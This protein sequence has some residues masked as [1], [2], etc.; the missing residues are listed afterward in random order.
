MTQWLALAGIATLCLGVGN[1]MAQDQGGPGGPG[2]GRQRGNFDPAQFQQRMMEG[3]RDRLAITDETEWN[4]I[5]P[6]VQKVMDLRRE[7]LGANM[8]GFGRG[9]R[10]G[11]FGGNEEVSNEQTALND[12]I[13]NNASKDDL[14]AKMAAFRK[15]KAEKEAELKTAQENLKKVLT[16]KQ[17]AVALQMGLVN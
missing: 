7:Q 16:T 2:G 1:V 12:A 4:A 13:E 8:R 10:G 9:G 11:G 6:L 14:K 3:V 15:A 5:Q 17:E